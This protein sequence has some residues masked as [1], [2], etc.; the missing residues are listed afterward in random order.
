MGL[1]HV[2]LRVSFLHPALAQALLWPRSVAMQ[3]FSASSRPA[4]IPGMLTPTYCLGTAG[5]LDVSMLRE[6]MA[7]IGD[8]K[9]ETEASGN[10][11]LETV[12][13]FSMLVL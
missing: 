8:R 7:L 6:A 11:T 5:G 9:I 12:R 1:R 4:G 3:L 10:V 13:G 2:G